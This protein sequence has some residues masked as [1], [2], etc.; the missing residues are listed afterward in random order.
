MQMGEQLAS[1]SENRALRDR[2]HPIVL[3]PERQGLNH[4]ND[5]QKKQNGNQ[6]A[7]RFPDDK[8]VDGLSDHKGAK[9]PEY[10]ADDNHQHDKDEQSFSFSQVRP[11]SL[12]CA[13]CILCFRPL[14][15]AFFLSIGSL[16]YWKG[17]QMSFSIRSPP[18]RIVTRKCAC[19][20]EIQKAVHCACL[21][22]SVRHPQAAKSH[23]LSLPS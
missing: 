23:Q 8:M 6:S 14:F 16:G 15:R 13:F 22:Q 10:G 2:N 18:F 3:K 4:V 19:I 5:E 17:L 20:T 12:Q 11:D 9:E 21:F 7:D 1:H